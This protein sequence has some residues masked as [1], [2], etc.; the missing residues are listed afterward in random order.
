MTDSRSLATRAVL[1]L[2]LMIGFYALALGISG[3]L[4]W[5]PYAEVVYLGRLHPKLALGCIFGAGAVLWA[6]L[7]RPDRFSPPGPQLTRT[8]A[9][10]LFGLIDQV[11]RCT[12]QA[13]PAE[14]YLLNDV[15]AWVTQRGGV[16]GIGSRRVMGVGLPL[17]A[18][19]T[20]SELAAV[21]AHEFGHYVSGDVGLGPWIYKTR[22]AIIRAAAA[23]HETWLAMPFRAYAELFLKT[24]LAVSREQEFVADRTAARVAGPAAAASALDRVATL[25]PA[26]DAYLDTEVRPLVQAGFLPPL[27]AGFDRYIRQPR[28]VAFM[29]EASGDRTTGAE[30]GE[31][32]TH[33]PMAERIAAL[34]RLPASAP[35]VTVP[36]RDPA[37][38]QLD[39]HA[40]ALM[41]HTLGAELMAGL[42]PLA[43]DQAGEVVYARRWHD[44]AQ[45]YAKWLGVRAVIDLPWGRKAFMQLGAGLVDPREVDVT[46]DDRVA[47]AMHVFTAGLGS[48]LLRAGWVLET[49]PGQPLELVNGAER[50]NP[51]EVILAPGGGAGNG[52]RLAGDLRP[53]WHRGTA[54]GGRPAGRASH[55]RAGRLG[56]NALGAVRPL[57]WLDLGLRSLVYRCGMAHEP[58]DHDAPSLSALTADITTL[59]VDAIV[60]AANESLRPG[61]GVCG[62]IHRAAGPELA[63]ACALVAPCPTGEARITPGFD[64]PASYV[65]HA[66]GPVWHGGDHGEA[67]QLASAYRRSL[68]LATENRLT[69]I[70]FPA[71]STG[72]YGYPLALATEVAVRT[73]RNALQP[74]TIRRV[75]FACFDQRVLDTYRTA[76]V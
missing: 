31:Y 47:R 37:L 57:L 49:G 50:L 33:P 27:A 20:P 41:R 11:A 6:I 4:L 44:M 59:N 54:S 2:A 13:P 38:G 36:A 3:A 19:L 26:Y 24:T 72:I 61:G 29:Q 51:G 68:E 46:D 14:V 64:L 45:E 65:I 8:N 30:A 21:I 10:A 40:R 12:A 25:A 76:G 48:A 23:T 55:S 43:W 66:V 28:I 1:A 34:E 16:M 39:G 71:I 62:A 58:S 22:A 53:A 42:R 17:L 18:H 35:A 74:S 15:N 5:I 70:A 32:D 63:R 67:E 73:V 69:S 56:P 7:P 60:N 75:V 9:P 52:R